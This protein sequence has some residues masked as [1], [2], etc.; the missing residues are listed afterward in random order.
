MPRC[1]W[2]SRNGRQA[3]QYAAQAIA[4]DPNSMDAHRVYATVLELLGQ[5]NAAIEEYL[6]A[7]A[8]QPQPD[9]PVRVY[10]AELPAPAAV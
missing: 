8:A 3:E 1:C 5:Y 9:I 4:L 2:T 10:R 7:S 6:R